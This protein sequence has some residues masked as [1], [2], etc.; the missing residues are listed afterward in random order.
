MDKSGVFR[1]LKG[2]RGDLNPLKWTKE[3][4]LVLEAQIKQL[5][6]DNA[7]LHEERDIL[8][9]EIALFTGTPQKHPALGY[10]RPV[11]FEQQFSRNSCYRGMVSFSARSRVSVRK[12]HIGYFKLNKL[13]KIYPAIMSHKLANIPPE[14]SG[15]IIGAGIKIN[16][17]IISITIAS[18][19]RVG[20]SGVISSNGRA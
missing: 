12:K 5:K 17:K 10:L 15:A 4:L 18:L 8:K 2:S 9:N 7:I 1:K 14:P 20:S 13:F 19:R 16:P 6:R 3:P 11:Q